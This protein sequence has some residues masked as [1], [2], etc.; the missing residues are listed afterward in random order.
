[1][2]HQNETFIFLACREHKTRKTNFFLIDCISSS[3]DCFSMTKKLHKSFPA[4]QTLRD[5]FLIHEISDAQFYHK[6]KYA[7]LVEQNSTLT[8]S[9]RAARS[10][11][12]CLNFFKCC[13][14]LDVVREKYNVIFSTWPGISNLRVPKNFFNNFFVTWA[15]KEFTYLL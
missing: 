6:L 11:S 14:L 15:Q 7:N 8:L 13:F 3:L 1:M 4:R 10:W 5:N 2:S 9:Y 12:L